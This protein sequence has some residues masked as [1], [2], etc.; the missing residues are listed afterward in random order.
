MLFV[1]KIAARILLVLATFV[2]PALGEEIPRQTDGRY[3]VQVKDVLVALPPEDPT[4]RMTTFN[5][6]APPG[7]GP[8]EFTLTDLVGDPE[9]YSARLQSS[10]WSS[11]RASQ[12]RPSEIL[13]EQVVKGVANVG[14]LSGV[15]TNCEAWR[16][17]WAHYREVAIGLPADQYGWTRQDDHRSPPTSTFIKFLDSGERAKSRY[18]PLSCDFSGS[19]LLKTCHNSLTAWIRIHSSN[20]GQ[21][22]DYSIKDF[23]QQI[24][25]G[26]KT[27]E[28][29][30]VNRPVDLA[31]P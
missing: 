21:G 17:L 6:S 11:V 12:T 31:Y 19:C 24:A 13:G 27:L 30:V 10:E 5:V 23:D 28:H 8:F 29:M 9:R 26:I 18:Y 15:D 14:V 3:E 16:P 1:H 22:E 2:A 25:S 4:R 7:K 20:K